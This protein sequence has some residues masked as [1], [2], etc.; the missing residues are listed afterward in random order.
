M[1]AAP[2]Y[3]VGVDPGIEGAIAVVEVVPG[4]ARPRLVQWWDVPAHLMRVGRGDR[5]RYDIH[6]LA[7]VVQACSVY[8]PA[9]FTVEDVMGRGN[10]R[11]S[12]IFGFGVGLMHMAAVAYG[13]PLGVVKPQTWKAQLRVPASKPGA[14]RRAEVLLEA[15]LGAFAGERGGLKD[16][17]AEAAMVAVWASLRR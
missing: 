11:G 4:A 10:Q 15:P 16:G 9:T 12:S 6:R 13:M 17:R 3:H 8:S 14:V 5:R 2:A 1:T 7:S